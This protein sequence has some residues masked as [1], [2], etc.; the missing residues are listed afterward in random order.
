MACFS[1]V[2][3][4]T[5]PRNMWNI[6]FFIDLNGLHVSLLL[7]S[8]FSLVLASTVPENIFHVLAALAT[9]LSS[10]LKLNNLSTFSGIWAYE[11]N[12]N[13]LI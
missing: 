1:K 12:A 11:I 4:Y 8:P 2:I 10:R 3:D 5:Y 7:A 6:L 13:S 9:F